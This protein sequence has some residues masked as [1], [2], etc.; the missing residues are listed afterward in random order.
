MLLIQSMKHKKKHFKIVSKLLQNRC[1][2]LKKLDSCAGNQENRG[3]S[4]YY[5][6]NGP[7]KGIYSN[8]EGSEGIDRWEVKERSLSS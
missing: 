6:A 4:P 3:G 8:R 1:K 5:G 2:R 7:Y